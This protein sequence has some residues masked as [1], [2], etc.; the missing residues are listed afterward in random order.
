MVS[1]RL[2]MV[3]KEKNK[4][5]FIWSELLTEE[6]F[7]TQCQHSTLQTGLN[8]NSSKLPHKNK[9]PLHNL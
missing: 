3:V 2:I 9:F 1:Y 5:I 4:D 6:M 7:D 8:A